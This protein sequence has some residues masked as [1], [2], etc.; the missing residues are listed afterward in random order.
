LHFVVST[1]C[2]SGPARILS[3]SIATPIIEQNLDTQCNLFSNNTL[4]KPTLYID[5]LYNSLPS[6][7]LFRHVKI[8]SLK[9][10]NG[11]DVI[12]NC[13]PTSWDIVA[14]NTFSVISGRNLQIRIIVE[15]PRRFMFSFSV[16]GALRHLSGT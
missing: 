14:S 9:T 13:H 1:E 2:N 8:S 12:D 7:L 15:T 3:A 6:F 16:R 4:S 11:I 10:Y 5:N